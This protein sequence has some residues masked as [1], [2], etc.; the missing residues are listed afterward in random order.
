MKTFQNKVAVVTG[1]ASGIGRAMAERFAAEGMK[2]VLA[3]VEERALA[4]AERYL[5]ARG[6]ATLAIRTDV[7]RA[8]DVEA[9]ARATIERFGAVHVVCNNAGVSGDGISTW[10]QSLETW[11]WVLGVNLW[12]IV[13]G[14]RTF[15]P[16]MLAQG[17]EGHVINTAS[18]AG[19]LSMPFLSVY[20]ATKFA[21]VSISECLHHELQ[22]IESPVKVSVL[23]PGFVRT[24]IIDA[25]RNRPPELRDDPQR[26]EAVQ[27]LRHAF[28]G[29]VESG[30]PPA[31]VAARVF[32]AVRDERFWIFPHPEML[33]AVRDRAATILAQE[34]PTFASPP[35]LELK[36]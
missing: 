27:A 33:E 31:E 12:G 29:F 11:Q 32:E 22:M 19:H 5:A 17:G 34:N 2:V 24:N 3:D 18:M 7:A 36:L 30:I 8:A 1:A 35:G 14:I 6:A 26:S 21:V 23:C 28:R 9:L 4:E 10:D 25:E 15:V 13:H 20:N 16:L